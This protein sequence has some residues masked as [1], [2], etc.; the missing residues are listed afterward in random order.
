M[1]LSRYF[2]GSKPQSGENGIGGGPL[3]LPFDPVLN[4]GQSFGGLM[5]VVAVGDVGKGFEQL[6]ET[7]AAVQDRGGYCLAGCS[8]SR[9]A[10][11]RSH[12]FDLT[13]PSAF[14]RRIPARVRNL[15]A[16]G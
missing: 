2:S 16:A 3:G 11:D 1:T 12:F 8:T 4:S 10:R 5:D 6:F 14:P 9:R 13:H 7:F 15:R